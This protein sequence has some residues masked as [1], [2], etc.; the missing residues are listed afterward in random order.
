[1]AKTKAKTNNTTKYWAI[2][3]IAVI[4]LFGIWLVSAYNGLVKLGLAADSSWANVESSYQRRMDLIPNLVNTV[5]GY[6]T[7]ET[8]LLTQITQLRSQWASATTTNQKI[9]TANQ[10]EGDLSKLMVVV[11]NYPDL[12]AN[13][14]FLA[15]QDELAGTENRIN[16]ARD[17]YNTAVQDY[18]TKTQVFPTRIIAG[19]FGFTQKTFFQAQ[20]GAENAPT[21][22]F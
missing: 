3:I 20:Q 9:D 14:N 11:E 18:N 4:V 19:M 17:R 1:M 21:V 12:K 10:M 5:K 7:H 8:D 16:V 6:A 2:G 22:T 15:L 13:Q